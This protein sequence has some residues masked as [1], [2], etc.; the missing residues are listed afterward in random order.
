MNLPLQYLK[1]ILQDIPQACFPVHS[2]V[3]PLKSFVFP[4]AQCYVKRDDELGFGISGSKIRKYRTLIPFFVTNG[5]QEVILIGSAYSNHVLSL[6]QLL[7]ENGIKPTLYLRGDPNRLVQGNSLLTS[8]FVSPS[9]IHWFSKPEW[10]HVESQAHD[11]AEQQQ[12]P[13]FVL[14]EGGFSPEAL[15]GALTLSVDIQENENN[16]GLNFDHIFIEAGTGFTASSLILGLHWLKRSTIVHVV[17]LAE[18]KANFLFRLKKCYDMF[19][20]LMQVSCPFPE[21]FILHLPHLTGTFGQIKPFLFET[22]V[23]IAREEGFLTDPVYTVK[24]FIESKHLLSQGDIQGNVLIHH[25]GG[26]MSLMGFQDQLNSVLCDLNK[27]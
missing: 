17:L 20:Q 14:L 21:N 26:A 9:S 22:I 1:D 24:L 6:Q 19:I 8:L 27:N 18:D 7:I 2:R 5:I 16:L 13:T 11:Y 23:S 15:P 25:S 4:S 3:H 10:R 12:H